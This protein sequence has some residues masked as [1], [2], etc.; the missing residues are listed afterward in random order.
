M[1]LAR[2]ADGY[3]HP[4]IDRR[5]VQPRPIPLRLNV[6]EQLTPEFRLARCFVVHL[7]LLTV[8]NYIT[9]SH[10]NLSRMHRQVQSVLTRT[11]H[12]PANGTSS[13]MATVVGA[14]RPC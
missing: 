3:S 2:L 5:L 13:R 10:Y 11:T 9:H 12:P 6:V 1:T 8:C 7:C 4:C 14:H